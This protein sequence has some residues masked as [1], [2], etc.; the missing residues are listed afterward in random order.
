MQALCSL[1]AQGQKGIDMAIDFIT[2]SEE[3]P[4][5][6]REAQRMLLGAWHGRSEADER[7]EKHSRH[8]D[9]KRMPVV[10]RAILRLAVWEM[11]S[12][13]ANPIVVVAESVRI[14]QE[15]STAESPRF[16]NGILMMIA[17]EMPA[18]PDAPEEEKE[19]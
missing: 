13:H 8:W 14:A 15:F 3:A 12:G 19:E 10:D 2:D 11:T 4:E 5:V 1:D 6:L 17:R 18:P 7:L 16:V 9:I